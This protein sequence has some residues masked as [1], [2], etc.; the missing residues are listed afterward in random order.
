MKVRI[1]S[2]CIIFLFVFFIFKIDSYQPPEHDLFVSNLFDASSN[3]LA[4]NQPQKIQLLKEKKE[5]GT[6]SNV[7][8]LRTV[9]EFLYFTIQKD[10]PLI[11]Y[12]YSQ[13]NN[14]KK[15]YH[16]LADFFADKITFL[17]ID[18]SKNKDLFG[19]IKLFINANNISFDEN[20]IKFPVIL[21]CRPKSLQ[22]KN[23]TLYFDSAALSLLSMESFDIS[24]LKKNIME[25]IKN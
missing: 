13:K 7:F 2:K 15:N 12:I 17:S 20:N 21:F 5:D 19:L 11:F 23:E 25:M 6:I 3:S 18:E 14:F 24:S 16:E 8:Y 1:V 4:V 9:P 22:I 10:L